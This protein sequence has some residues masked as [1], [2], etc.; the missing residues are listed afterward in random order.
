MEKNNGSRGSGI[1][2]VVLFAA[3]CGAVLY[4]KLGKGEKAD[5]AQP[6]AE[7][8]AERDKDKPDEPRLEILFASSDGKK[9]WVNDAVKAFNARGEKVNGKKVVVK[10]EHMRSGES[11]QAIL[12]GKSKPTI[13]GPAGKSWVELINQDWQVRERKPFLGEP[14]DTVNTALIIAL[15]EPMARALGWPQKEIGWGDLHAVA[16]NPKGWAAYGHPEWGNF[17]FGH[18][19]PDYSN[20]AML[21]VVSL[22]YAGA[23]KTQGL[24]AADMKQPKVVKLL[25]ELEEAIVHYGES[26][27]WLAD[28]LC[29]RGPAYLSAVTLYESSV[30]KANDKCTAKPFPLVAVYPKEGTFW[31][32][33]PAAIVQADW[34]TEEMKEGAGKF[35]DFLTSR[36]QQAKA[37][38]F[39]FRPAL[40]GMAL[41]SPF[42]A[43]HGV[44]PDA[45]RKELEYLSE[46]LFQRANAL[47]HEV[48]KKASVW[49]LLDTSGSMKGE[50]MEAAKKGAIG[51]LKQM[52]PGDYVR[53]ISFNSAVAPLG[54]A[55][56]VREVG[57]SLGERVAG[58][59]AEGNTAL[60]D[61]L[62]FALDEVEK[63][64]AGS[65]DARSFGIVLLSDGRDTSSRS[66]RPDVFDRL[67][68]VEDTAGTRVF[69]IAYGGEADEDFL[70]NVSE[71]SNAVMLKGG[72]ADVEKL[73]HQIASY[74]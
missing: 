71:R 23:G 52:E 35:L 39:G 38:T 30:V 31:E 60:H 42:D 32:T 16:T 74:F 26:S 67:P 36:E 29:Q 27:S 44:N 28:K 2:V 53:V 65:K 33:H 3:V 57:E 10:A 72:S 34:V 62:V 21:S 63:A 40:A 1:A 54:N 12:A 70:K 59:Y 56:P 9:E 14:R 69:S 4:F 55:G 7:R 8:P 37:P 41:Q 11:R 50:P 68:K 18:S 19:H 25:R 47:W 17:K 61:S 5:G 20:S 46:D 49:V 15:W 24:T 48:K 51:F 73:Y 45:Q 64:R 22:V 66:N 43:A 13:W 58:L 6:T